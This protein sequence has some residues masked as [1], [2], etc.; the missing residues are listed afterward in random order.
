MGSGENG[1]KCTDWETAVPGLS[2]AWMELKER[3]NVPDPRGR[4]AAGTT[5]LRWRRP[6]GQEGADLD[7]AGIPVREKG[8]L[9][10]ETRGSTP[11]SPKLPLLCLPGKRHC[12]CSI[13]KSYPTLQLHEAPLSFSRRLLRFMPTEL[14]MLS[15]YLILCRP[16]LL[17]NQGLFR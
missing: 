5:F 11:D 3:E 4:A 9:P 14:V 16:L 10:L 17:L 7:Q 6:G 12:C 8:H 2:M 1:A 13:A 15:N